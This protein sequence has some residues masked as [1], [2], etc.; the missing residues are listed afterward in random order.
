M[1]I[2]SNNKELI[3][4]IAKLQ[5]ASSVSKVEGVDEDPTDKEMTGIS[6]PVCMCDYNV[7]LEVSSTVL[8]LLCRPRHA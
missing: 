6:S 4:G 5:D 1:V 8:L 2:L 7:V 3:H